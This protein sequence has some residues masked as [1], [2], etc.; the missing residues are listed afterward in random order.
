M[1][2]VPVVGL[3]RNMQQTSTS[4]FDPFGTTALPLP[5]LTAPRAAAPPQMI[6][7]SLRPLASNLLQNPAPGE[8]RYR[9]LD[10]ESG[11]G[12]PTAIQRLEHSEQDARGA[13]SARA[14]H[15]VGTGETPQYRA[16]Q[17]RPTQEHFSY[18]VRGEELSG[19]RGGRGQ[20]R[21]GRGQSAGGRWAQPGGGR[22]GQPGGGRGAQPVGGCGGQPRGGRG[23]WGE[24]GKID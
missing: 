20:P 1:A 10:S 14:R 9:G 3:E 6:I 15:E 19:V 18:G 2:I 13:G 24:R 12:L 16:I 4:T 8:R 11:N 22:G 7:S 23:G 5:L 21:G 17:P